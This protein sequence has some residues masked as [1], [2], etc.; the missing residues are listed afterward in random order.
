MSGSDTVKL[1]LVIAG[2][3]LALAAA[4]GCSPSATTS[5]PAGNTAQSTG[6][7]TSSP[8]IYPFE[9]QQQES[10]DPALVKVTMCR[11][12]KSSPGQLSALFQGEV[13]NTTTLSGTLGVE[14]WFSDEHATVEH[15]DNLVADNV[16]PGQLAHIYGVA[17]DA[18]DTFPGNKVTCS[19]KSVEVYT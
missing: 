13:T 17:S 6:P 2:A 12:G 16:Q 15:M 14:V 4:T 7:D 3:V 5:T 10:I 1:A 8:G 9:P 19:V 11:I 18:A